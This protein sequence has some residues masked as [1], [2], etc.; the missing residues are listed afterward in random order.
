AHLSPTAPSR[1]ASVS[2]CRSLSVAATNRCHLPLT[3]ASFVAVK[4]SLCR[5][6]RCPSLHLL[7]ATTVAATVAPSYRHLLLLPLLPLLAPYPVVAAA[8]AAPLRQP[9]SPSSSVTNHS[10]YHQQQPAASSSPLLPPL[11]HINRDRSCRLLY[12]R[13]S[14]SPASSCC[15]LAKLQQPSCRRLCHYRLLPFAPSPT[16]STAICI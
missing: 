4:P 13:Q 6:N 1:A 15:H 7:T 14:S 11:P 5:S 10:H 16:P 3:A 8:T 9:P 2:H 12:H